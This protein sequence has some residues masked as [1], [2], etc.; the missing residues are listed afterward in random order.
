MWKFLCLK[1]KLNFLTQIATETTIINV[2]PIVIE[3]YINLKCVL[4]LFI[5]NDTSTKSKYNK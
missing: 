1:L 3:T 4:N 2:T 5:S